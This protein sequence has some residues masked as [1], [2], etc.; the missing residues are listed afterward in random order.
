[1]LYTT[2][3]SNVKSIPDRVEKHLVVRKLPPKFD[4]NKY[5]DLIHTP[6]L[7]PSLMLLNWSKAEGDWHSFKIRF[8]R[9][10]ESRSDMQS[11]MSSMERSLAA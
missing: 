6:E 11:A 10:M 2:Y 9:E 5:P 8:T 7:S 4:L 3:L 1:M